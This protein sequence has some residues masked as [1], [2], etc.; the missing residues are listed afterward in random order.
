MKYNYYFFKIFTSTQI[1]NHYFY[2]QFLNYS[3]K[4]KHKRHINNTIY[5]QFRSEELKVIKCKTFVFFYHITC[6]LYFILIF[7]FVLISYSLLYL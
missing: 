3:Y 7:N 5:V 1:L 2:Q 4:L 6:I